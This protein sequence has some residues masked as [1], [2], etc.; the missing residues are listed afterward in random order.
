MK[1]EVRPTESSMMKI[2][3]SCRILD[4]AERGR[5]ADMGHKESGRKE[6]RDNQ[7]PRMSSD[8]DDDEH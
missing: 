6:E 8:D 2:R 5:K 4:A 7:R 3:P 1:E